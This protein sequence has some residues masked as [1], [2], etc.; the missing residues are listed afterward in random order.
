MR[1]SYLY[2]FTETLILE[3]SSWLA[4]A[5]Q[6]A[7]YGLCQPANGWLEFTYFP[8]GTTLEQ[9]LLKLRRYITHWGAP[10][11]LSMDGGTNL[12]SEQMWW[13]TECWSLAHY[14]QFNDWAEVA[15][16]VV[17]RILCGNTQA[18]LQYLNTPLYG[19]DKSPAQLA[20]GKKQKNAA[21][22]QNG[23]PTLK[24]ITTKKVALDIPQRRC[25]AQ[26]CGHETSSILGC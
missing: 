21:P 19:R 23:G 11:E 12:T 3:N 4:S 20:M 18:L 24:S 1:T 26:W 2:T 8:C 10:E 16:K 6:Q 25:A 7:I 22:T 13:I 17:K 9:T 14:P 5:G 15:V